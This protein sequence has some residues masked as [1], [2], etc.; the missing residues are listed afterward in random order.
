VGEEGFA[1]QLSL[2][3]SVA[4]AIA[5]VQQAIAEAPAIGAGHGPLNHAITVHPFTLQ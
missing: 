4:R 5:Y 1:Q 3:D 2:L